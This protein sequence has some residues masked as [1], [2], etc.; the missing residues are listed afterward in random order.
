MENSWLFY[1]TKH[2]LTMQPNSGTLGHLL[3]INENFRL[4]INTY[5]NV[6]SSFIPKSPRL[7]TTQV[8][9]SGWMTK[10]DCIYTTG[11]SPIERRQWLILG[12]VGWITKK[13][14]WVKSQALK[15]ICCMIV[16]RQHFLHDNAL[17]RESALVVAR[18]SREFEQLGGRD[19][20]V[21]INSEHERF[22][23]GQ[24]FCLSWI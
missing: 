4:L 18:G 2:V 15:F 23:W 6:Y 8:S 14:C 22:L 9:F 3:Q 16:F 10:H 20:D 7:E 12:T 13:L 21:A 11:Y 19:A 5:M 17:Y 24:N 1:K